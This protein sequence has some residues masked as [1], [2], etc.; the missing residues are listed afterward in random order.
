LAERAGQRVQDLL[1]PASSLAMRR[2]AT[3]C[4]EEWVAAS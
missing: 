4:G 1:A 3:H 2:A